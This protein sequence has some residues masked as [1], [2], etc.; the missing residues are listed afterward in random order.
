MRQIR[1]KTPF[2]VTGTAVDFFFSLADP[3]GDAFSVA[4]RDSSDTDFL[5]ET[6]DPS[7]MNRLFEYL[8]L[9]TPQVYT[10]VNTDVTWSVIGDTNNNTFQVH[11]DTFPSVNATVPEPS[12]IAI[13]S[14]LAI[15]CMAARGD[16]G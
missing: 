12:S 1:C 8:P 4:L 6:N 9:S 3:P 16:G 7:H 2:P 14:L 11:I 15:A 5:V 13:W 10:G